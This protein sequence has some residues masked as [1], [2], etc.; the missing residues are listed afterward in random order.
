MP[1][2]TSDW[3]IVEQLAGVF[4]GRNPD[5][6]V[7]M[8]L[9]IV[10]AYIEQIVAQTPSNGGSVTFRGVW[11]ATYDYA[12]NDL[13][14]YNSKVYLLIAPSTIISST[15]PDQDPTNWLCLWGQQVL[16]ADLNSVP[17]S[18]FFYSQGAANAPTSDP[19]GYGFTLYNGTGFAIQ[20][21]W[22]ASADT[23][24]TRYLNNGTWLQW[25][26]MAST[27]QK[28]QVPG[29]EGSGTIY[30]SPVN[31][32]YFYSTITVA[33]QLNMAGWANAN[34]KVQRF[35]WEIVNG[36]AFA[37][38]W[39]PYNNLH[40]VKSDGTLTTDF[41]TLGVT[42]NAAGSN[43]FEFWTRDSGATVYGRA[44]R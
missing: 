4:F 7:Q 11:S 39:G 21:Y 2:K 35:Q 36:G 40:W 34:G 14:S 26:V 41:T 13:V 29:G 6:N 23:L 42:W 43:F 15:T 20:I 12:P 3:P 8:P 1:V 28:A 33:T 19:T 44:L 30:A 9:S 32:G 38:T 18:A 10:Q 25:N 5:G 17:A 31:N 24:Y 22:N 37:T 16:A 27:F